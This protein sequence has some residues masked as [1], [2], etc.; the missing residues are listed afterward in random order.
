MKRSCVRFGSRGNE[1]KDGESTL[2]PRSARLN[3][4]HGDIDLPVC[5]CTCMFQLCVYWG[6]SEQEMDGVRDEKDGIE[7]RTDDVRPRREERKTEQ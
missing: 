4:N 7:T 1:E 6:H 2:L 3:G 5:L